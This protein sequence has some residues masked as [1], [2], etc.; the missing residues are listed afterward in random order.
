MCCFFLTLDGSIELVVLSLYPVEAAVVIGRP[1]K[2]FG[3]LLYLFL[4]DNSYYNSVN[5]NDYNVLVYL[6]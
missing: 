6:K 2:S 5:N 1:A 3:T 4:C